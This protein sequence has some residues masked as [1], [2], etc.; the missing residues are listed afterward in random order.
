MTTFQDGPAKG[1]TLMLRR[2]PAFL[3]VTQYKKDFDALDLAS[4]FPRDEEILYAYQL[5][6]YVGVAHINRGSRG[7][8]WYPIAEYRMVQPQPE[9]MFM[10]SNVEWERWCE[11]AAKKLSTPNCG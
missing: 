3:R 7:G 6:K 5:A 4:D 11:A 1:K 2:A 9:A 8:G 10:R